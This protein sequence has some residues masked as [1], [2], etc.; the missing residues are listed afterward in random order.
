MGWLHPFFLLLLM[1]DVISLVGTSPTI[2]LNDCV[3]PVRNCMLF[4]F[5]ADSYLVSAP[6]KFAVLASPSLVS[7][8]LAIGGRVIFT[9]GY[10]ERHEFVIVALGGSTSVNEVEV[11]VGA[12]ATWDNVAVA[13]SLLPYWSLNYEINVGGGSLGIGAYWLG[14][15]WNVGIEVLSASFSL[16]FSSAVS[17]DMK[18]LGNYRICVQ[19]V[20]VNELC[21]PVNSISGQL[22]SWVVNEVCKVPTPN[23]D[24]SC[25]MLPSSV[26][27]WSSGF[28]VAGMCR[29]LF[30]R[31]VPRDCNKVNMGVVYRSDMV[32]R[33]F[34]RYY[35]VRNDGSGFSQA[36]NFYDTAVYSFA[37]VGYDD[38]A[39]YA[40]WMDGL[41]N[42]RAIL[43]VQQPFFYYHT[44]LS[45]CHV[46]VVWLGGSVSVVMP[47]LDVRWYVSGAIWGSTVL[48][49][50]GF[51]NDVG[52][53]EIPFT[54]QGLYAAA[55]VVSGGS[56]PDVS[57]ITGFEVRVLGGSA[58][59]PNYWSF[60]FDYQYCCQHCVDYII[61]ENEFGG[62]DTLSVQCDKSEFSNLNEE[63][64]RLDDCLSDGESV[65]R[66]ADGVLE[67]N[68]TVNTLPYNLGND[69][70]GVANFENRAVERLLKSF[71][72]AGM[73]FMKVNGVFRKV[74]LR[75]NDYSRLTR[76]WEF[77]L[78]VVY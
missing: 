28:D 7:G 8:N 37:D 32:K 40:T 26:F 35:S 68:V 14:S 67:W 21:P 52:F 61:F 11:G 10:G 48:G 50:S 27:S 47:T 57:L 46:A 13:F 4:E 34:L 45:A 30:D 9:N 1:A 77:K 15:L 42:R 62:W 72:D 31:R 12:S 65:G 3:L 17:G 25:P 38:G 6:A 43:S 66:W 5:S 71:V 53:Y 41:C 2:G 20:C 29:G 60:G 23:W 59:M 24:I 69:R 63:F 56:I 78:G 64:C 55:V 51:A 58:V 22:A 70:L 49:L 18:L 39:N 76:C 54:M 75:S 16:S 44:C 36:Q 33:C 74:I 73:G 19:L